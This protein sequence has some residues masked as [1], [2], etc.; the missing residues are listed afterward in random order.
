MLWF[1][2][3]SKERRS[4]SKPEFLECLETNGFKPVIEDGVVMVV[5]DKIE[6]YDKICELAKKE[7]YDGSYGW[8][9]IHL[10]E[11]LA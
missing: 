8:R 5:T 6:D 1:L 9:L 2:K 3:K 11:N 7:G 10:Y 4:M